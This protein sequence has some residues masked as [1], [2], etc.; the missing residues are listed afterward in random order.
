MLLLRKFRRGDSVAR[1][2]LNLYAAEHK[3]RCSED[4]AADGRRDFSKSFYKTIDSFQ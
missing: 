4:S 1:Y 3:V 2:N